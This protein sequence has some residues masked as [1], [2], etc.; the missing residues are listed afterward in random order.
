MFSAVTASAISAVRNLTF[1]HLATIVF[2][3]LVATIACLMP[4][5]S[6]TWWQL[7]AGQE[8]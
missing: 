6:D 5:Q 4:I 3:I 2:F 7:R 1:D 8:F